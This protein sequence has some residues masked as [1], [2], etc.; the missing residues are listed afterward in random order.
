MKAL[1]K[2][3]VK[4]FLQ[5][6]A[7]IYSVRRNNTVPDKY[8]KWLYITI[9]SPLLLVRSMWTHDEIS[10]NYR[11]FLMSFTYPE[12]KFR[13]EQVYRSCKSVHPE[14]YNCRDAF[15]K[16]FLR[17]IRRVWRMY[18]RLYILQTC[19]VLFLSRKTL[20]KKDACNKVKQGIVHALQSTAFLAGQ[21]ILQRILLCTSEKLDIQMTPLKLYMI[22][23]LG[24]VPVLFERDSRVKQVN[25]LVLSHILVGTER[26]LSGSLSPAAEK[27][28]VP[29]LFPLFLIVATLARE[30]GTLYLLSLVISLA[31]AV[32]F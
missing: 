1:A 30:K 4:E 19:I 18:T 2:N 15:Y 5:I 14:E 29:S 27:D 25:N 23:M 26:K 3:R 21:T 10:Y 17:S 9:L 11:K 8:A 22:S 32:T 31:T 20:G 28:L 16:N 12:C 13:K 7:V 24:S 6:A